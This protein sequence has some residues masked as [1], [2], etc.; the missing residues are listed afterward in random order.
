MSMK[1]PKIVQVYAVAYPSGLIRHE[2]FIL[3]N[4]EVIKKSIDF[5]DKNKIT[6]EK[7]TINDIE[8]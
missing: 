4:G 7:I 1:K 8:Q 5:N 3:D 2:Y 6:F